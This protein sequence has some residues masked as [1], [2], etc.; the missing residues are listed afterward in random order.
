MK[1]ALYLRLLS[2]VALCSA[3]QGLAHAS[4]ASWRIAVDVAPFASPEIAAKSEA[5]FAWDDRNSDEAIACTLG[6]AAVELRD[7]LEAIIPNPVEFAPLAESLGSQ[8]I[9][10]ST[11]EQARGLPVIGAELETQLSAH[12]DLPPGSFVIL[13]VAEGV[14]IVGQDRTGALY[15]VYSFLEYQGI[16]WYGPEAHE[17]HWP[18]V[19]AVALPTTAIVSTPDFATRGFWVREDKGNYDFYRWMARNRMNY[20]SIAEPDRAFLQ[21]L[22]MHLTFGGHH[23]WEKYLDPNAP[24]PFSLAGFDG[25][26]TLPADPY[27]PPS[28]EFRGDQDGDGILTF[29]EARPEWYGLNADGEREPF[30]G[31]YGMNIASSNPAPLDYLYQQIIKELTV[32]EWQDVDSLN[33]W[34]IDNGEWSQ[35]PECLALGEPTD[36]LLLMVHGLDQAIDA[37]IADGRMQRSIKIIF[38]IYQQ[39]LPPPTRPLP[40][41]FDY[42]TNIGTF[43]PILRCYVHEIDDPTCTEY[44]ARHWESFQG[45]T[46][47]EDRH[48]QGEIFVGEYFNVSVNKSLPVI[49]PRIIQNDIATYYRVGARHMHYM[50]TDTRLLGVKRINNY[51][52]AR[53]LW[54][55]DL[56]L[57]GE[58]DR[59]F[60]D[61]YGPVAGDMREVYDELEFALSNIK[62]L[63]YWHHLPEHIID[64]E[65]PL[66]HTQHFQ[67]ERTE[68]D[69]DDGVDLAESVAA[70][71]RLRLQLDTILDEDVDPVIRERLEI[72]DQTIRY[73]ENTVFFYDAVARAM[74]AEHEGD[75]D[76]ARRE[77][78]RSLQ[79]A[80]V[81]KAETEVVQ[82]A[83]NH[84]VHAH[85]GLHATRIEEAYLA[86]GT[87]LDPE[88][89]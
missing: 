67:L 30:E 70:F 64:G 6:Y 41:G 53:K 61:L 27:G 21:K 45:W 28:D 54:D 17:T 66:F 63:R 22:G 13:P 39:T 52:F 82:T 19:S 80:A 16:R 36:R 14:A 8:T 68:A 46:Q 57:S 3:T 18:E 81:L 31:M 89:N 38:P 24:Y 2:G 32:G 15:G 42:E 50:H 48:Y 29:F 20:W 84:H 25:D 10:V 87:R 73:G 26:D 58:I 77:Y 11:L 62:Q 1:F 34:S 59:Y 65:F 47:G 79:Y 76:L 44:N 74:L 49:Y 23:Y 51:L 55:H 86:L 43:F 9:T 83:T 88:R 5:E 33:F 60:D 35:S 69:I 71:K 40:A 85:D 12:D 4:S 56:D 72:D 7:H 78:W 37:A 75:L